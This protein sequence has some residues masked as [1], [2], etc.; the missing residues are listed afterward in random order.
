MAHPCANSRAPASMPT[1]TE[2]SRKH[3]LQGYTC[4]ELYKP[5]LY[6]KAGVRKRW[7][8]GPESRTV[9][10]HIL[11]NGKYVASAYGDEGVAPVRVLEGCEID[12]ADAFAE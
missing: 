8:A 11:E 3:S 9:A 1:R 2:Y 4:R 6:Q 5:R 7:I 12:L 10:A